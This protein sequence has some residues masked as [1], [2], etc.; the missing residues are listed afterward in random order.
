MLAARARSAIP[1]V[2]EWCKEVSTALCTMSLQCVL[3]VGER[4]RMVCAMEE[5]SHVRGLGPR[6]TQ[7]ASTVS[8]HVGVAGKHLIALLAHG[9]HQQQHHRIAR[10]P[11]RLRSTPASQRLV[12][13][14]AERQRSLA[15]TKKDRGAQ[16][17]V[18]S[19]QVQSHETQAAGRGQGSELRERTC[20]K[21]E[22]IGC[23]ELI[24]AAPSPSS[25]G[26]GAGST[27]TFPPV[28][29]AS[30]PSGEPSSMVSSDTAAP[31]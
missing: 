24:P 20:S 30:C 12:E 8:L 28:V 3:K 25:F 5:D 29:P 18:E 4:W 14:K 26:V 21:S 1:R 13:G 17:M 19:R 11:Q 23:T 15:V 31:T 2:W 22:P 6:L 10:Q 16:G 27:T 9:L 7:L